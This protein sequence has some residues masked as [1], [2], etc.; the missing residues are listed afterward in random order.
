MV[1]EA[2]IVGMIKDG[3]YL[4]VRSVLPKEEFKQGGSKH[5]YRYEWPINHYVFSNR[6]EQHMEFLGIDSDEFDKWDFQFT[7]RYDHTK[8][9][10]YTSKASV[11]YN[12]LIQVA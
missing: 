12:K 10:W 7:E 3:K 6:K 9:E 8:E 11:T 1:Q 2:Y 5:G 4:Q